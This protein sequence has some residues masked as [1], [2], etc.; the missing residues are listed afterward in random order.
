MGCVRRRKSRV[1]SHTSKILLIAL[2]IFHL[3]MYQ[4]PFMALMKTTDVR[5]QSTYVQPYLWSWSYGPHHNGCPS[6][7]KDFI[8]YIEGTLPDEFAKYLKKNRTI[9]DCLYVAKKRN[10]SKVW[11]QENNVKY[12]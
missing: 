3:M 1:E 11:A 9:E 5:D 8:T 7:D 12:N 2:D 4:I 10:E 6:D